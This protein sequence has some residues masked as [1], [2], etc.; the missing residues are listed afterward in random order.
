MQRPAGAAS[1]FDWDVAAAAHAAAEQAEAQA[2][3]KAKRREEPP[4]APPL[5]RA[6]QVGCRCAALPA[7]SDALSLR[8]TAEEAALLAVRAG[9]GAADAQ[10]GKLSCAVL[11]QRRIRWVT[12]LLP[13]G[14]QPTAVLPI[15]RVGGVRDPGIIPALI[16]CVA[17]DDLL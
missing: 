12:R 13:L 11:Q 15:A 14:M 17:L 2:A 10:G 5:N 6:M 16:L 1:I 3:R 9:S 4:P 7:P 8:G